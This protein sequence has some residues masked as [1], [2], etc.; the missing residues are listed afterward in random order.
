MKEL[1]FERKKLGLAMK[2]QIENRV[3]AY[4]IDY[5]SQSSK[6]EA[7]IEQRIEDLRTKLEHI[8]FARQTRREI[9][10]M[11]YRLQ[12]NQELLANPNALLNP[13]TKEIA[14]D[15]CAAEVYKMCNLDLN[16]DMVE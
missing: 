2:S 3:A 4:L 8:K 7:H 12:L 14:E 5:D 10:Q 1:Q 15:P 6:L 9:V 13:P 11:Q 16:S